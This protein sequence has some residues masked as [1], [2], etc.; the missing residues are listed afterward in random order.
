MWSSWSKVEAKCELHTLK[1]PCRIA[2][3]I[4]FNMAAELWRQWHQTPF[5][6]IETHTDVPGADYS[7]DEDRNNGYHFNYRHSMTS[8]PR[9]FQHYYMIPWE[10][11]TS[12][13]LNDDVLESQLD[14]RFFLWI[15]FSL[16]Q[17][18]NIIIHECLL[19]LTVRNIKPLNSTIDEPF[20]VPSKMDD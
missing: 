13:L 1:R 20:I 7:V 19:S 9:A 6:I 15:Y 5:L 3:L 14:L 4:I 18:K 16:S 17:Q 8:F 2:S 12:Q 10:W 11:K